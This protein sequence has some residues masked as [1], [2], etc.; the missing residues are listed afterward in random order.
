M[1]PETRGTRASRLAGAALLALCVLTVSAHAQI[2]IQ[3]LPAPTGFVVDRANILTPAAEKKLV[4]I[5]RELKAKTGAEIAIVTVTT[6][7][8]EPTFDYAMAIAEAWKPGSKDKDN[9]VVFLVATEDRQMQILTGYGA[10]GA[11]PDGRVGEIRDRI[12]RPAFREGRYNEGVLAATVEMAQRLAADQGVKLTGMPEVRRSRGRNGRS[13][14]EH[15]FFLLIVVFFLLGRAVEARRYMR[16]HK[17]Y[18]LG[19]FIAGMIAGRALSRGSRGH[20]GHS[21]Y[22]SFGGGFGG[23]GGGFGGFGGGGFGGGGAG[24]GW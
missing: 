5:N 4:D 22:G 20:W 12:V 3:D 21:G 7:G 13:E 17:Q 8:G 6:T 15:Y 11:L 23:G 24:G 9:G 10:E 18:G 1:R 14:A 19:A 2:P 16:H